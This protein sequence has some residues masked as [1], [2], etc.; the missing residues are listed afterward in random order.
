MRDYNDLSNTSVGNETQRYEDTT[1][2]LAQALTRVHAHEQQAALNALAAATNRL[3][4]R[5]Y[6]PTHPATRALELIN[7]AIDAAM[8]DTERKRDSASYAIRQSMQLLDAATEHESADE[9]ELI[10]DGGRRVQACPFCDEA[11]LQRRIDLERARALFYCNSCMTPVEEPHER[12][13]YCN[14]G[15][16]TSVR[17]EES[18]PGVI[19][20][21]D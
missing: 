14:G 8:I 10:A 12:D 6:G 2:L 16:T 17:L 4:G 3:G 13:A 18:E 21:D 19:G 7:A 1:N 20:G 9:G 11:D 15:P 5:T